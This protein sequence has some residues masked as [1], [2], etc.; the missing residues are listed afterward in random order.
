MIDKINTISLLMIILI[1]LPH[2]A[3]DGAVSLCLEIKKKINKII[4]LILYVL[5]AI[6][7]TLLWILFPEISLIL[8]LLISIFH[9]G[10]GDFEWSKGYSKYLLAYINGGIVIFGISLFNYESTD[11]IFKFLANDT[12]VVWYFIEYGTFLLIFLIPWF[13]INI[14]NLST[15]QILRIF[16]ICL[17][18]IFLPPLLSLSIY[19]CFIHSLNHFMRIIP[20][21]KSQ[22]SSTKIVNLFI[23]FTF[24]SWILGYLV[25]N[26]FSG[27]VNQTE[28]IYKIVFIGLAALTVPHML[29]IDLYFRPKKEI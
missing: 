28:L 16:I 14:S 9:F 7:V 10:L 1:G 8:F 6:I 21:L 13:V 22:M 3:L 24:A 23:L 29:L 26:Y 2:G 4:F 17:L 20:A 5:V 11:N 25:F 15:F 12:G 18:V 19:F 27:Q